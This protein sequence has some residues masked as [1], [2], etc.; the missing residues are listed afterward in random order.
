[1]TRQI[2]YKATLFLLPVLFAVAASAQSGIVV[3]AIADRNK[4]LIGQPIELTLKADIPENEAISFFSIDSIPHFEFL[5]KQK[6]DTTNTSSGTLLTQVIRITSF[7]SGHWVIPSFLLSENI[8]TDSIPVD[9]GFSEFNRNQEYHDIKD[10]VDVEVE[11]KKQPWWWYAVGGGLLLLLIIL[12]L[13]LR[14]KPVHSQVQVAAPVNA[15]EDAMSQLSALQVG[16]YEIKQYYSLL[17]DIFRQYVARRKG[18]SSLQKTT[19]DLILQLKE[20]TINKGVFDN[21]VQALRMSDFVKFAK[22]Q[23][24]E[25][26]KKGSLQAIRSAITAIE[27]TEPAINTRET[28]RHLTETAVAKNERH[29]KDASKELMDHL[30]YAMNYAMDQ[31][32]EGGVM[33]P[34]AVVVKGKEKVIQAYPEGNDYG[35][36]IFE[37]TIREEHPDFVVYAGDGSLTV[38]GKEWAAILFKAYDKNDSVMY[39]V[40]QRYTPKTATQEFEKNGN[41]AFIGTEKKFS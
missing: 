6:I 29:L 41:P 5:E 37:K 18:I 21:L 39:R 24:Q 34:F 33:M 1:M 31:K 36:K 15:Y 23:P 9:V 38:E 26:D 17:A 2:V 7:D 28:A 8:T 27:Q 35:V 12:Y 4:I 14:K 3:S 30:L 20:I 25:E 11:E 22:Y 10:V 13:V 16:H 32:K 40:A 19:D